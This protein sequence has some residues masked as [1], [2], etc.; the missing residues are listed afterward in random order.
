VS[1]DL[2]YTP[3][4]ELIDGYRA[5]RLSPVEA[6]QAALDRIA[7]HN[8]TLNAFLLVDGEG[9]LAAARESEARWAKGQSLGEVDGVPTGIKD[10]VLSKGWPTLRGSRT[11]DADQ[12]WDEDA[13]CVARLREQGAV[14][15]GKTTTPEFGWKGLT[16]GPLTGI[17]RNPWNTDKTP[18]G[19]SGGAS[20]ALAAGMGT[21][22]I[23]TDGAGS[24]RIP[25]GFTGVFG[26]K[27]TFG[28]VPAYPA[29]P[30]GTISHVGPMART[31]RDAALMLDVLALPDSRD[32]F[33]LPHEQRSWRAGLDEG[34]AGMRVAFSPALG[35]AKVDPEVAEIVA[36]AARAFEDL[37]AQVE[38]RDPGFED[39]TGSCR[40]HWYA[41]AAAALD[42]LPPEKKALLEEPL[43]EIVAKGS[44]I[45]LLDYLAAVGARTALGQ[46]MNRFHEDFDLLLTPALAVPAFDV[47][48]L[49]PEGWEDVDWMRWTPFT[50]P[51][52][53]TQ[54]PACSIPCG[55][56]ADGLPV[57]LQIVGPKFGDDMVLRA[58]RAY[59]TANPLHDRRP[60][61]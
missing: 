32:W 53:L 16:D 17:T 7:V 49:W 56:T 52:N 54:Q 61:L 10:I 14:F 44:E 37:G 30:F 50:Y 58:A 51:F 5:K 6:T 24:I 48:L 41:G 34:V 31:V 1:E 9:A 29:S 43:A 59:E 26:F 22:H 12:A 45:R 4:T 33:A 13:P 11:V 25:A 46:H 57:G 42:G 19:S 18:G 36:T 55:F 35:Y 60:S 3:A 40:V 8:E 21:L 2:A 15:L 23:G 39:P 38:D 28:R 27:P 20:A 47:G